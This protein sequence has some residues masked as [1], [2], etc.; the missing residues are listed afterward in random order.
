[1]CDQFRTI[2]G[3]SLPQPVIENDRLADWV[4]LEWPLS[5][6]ID[7]ISFEFYDENFLINLL[8]FPYLMLSQIT[9]FF[10]SSVD[11]AV[12]TSLD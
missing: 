6:F 4:I 2:Y 5:A 12:F 10:L 3:P 11:F 1:M 9:V 7:L 8:S